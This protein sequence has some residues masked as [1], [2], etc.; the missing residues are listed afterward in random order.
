MGSTSM[1][2]DRGRRYIDVSGIDWDDEAAI[3]RWAHTAWQQAMTDWGNAVTPAPTAVLDTTYAEA[4]AYAA[5]VHGGQVRKGTSIPYISHLL[6]VSSLILEAGG[7]QDEAIA[8]LL[9][10]AVEDAGGLR[11]LADIRARFGERV[12]EIVLLCSDSTDEE[13]KRRTPYWSR[14]RAYLDHLEAS[15]DARAVLVSIADKVHN[16][17]AIVTDLQWHGVRVLTKFNGTPGETL[18]YYVECLRIAED[19]QLP[20]TL[21]WSLY[22]AV[23]EIDQYIMSQQPA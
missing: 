4:V 18:T 12:A 16:A 22:T 21:L 19:R 17:R 20:E 23:A 11:T 7:D 5:E 13:W 14:K 10:D 15:D 6:G 1:S 8:G 9:H 2:P 3:D